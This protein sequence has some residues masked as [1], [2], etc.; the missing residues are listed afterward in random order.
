MEKIK[1]KD[2]EWYVLEINKKKAKLLLAD[3]LDERHIKKYVDDEWYRNGFEVR[4]NFNIKANANGWENSYI[5]N[6]VLENFKKDLGIDCK[7]TLLTQSEIFDLDEEIRCCNEDYWTKTII[8][9]DVYLSF[10]YVLNHGFS[11]YSNASRSLGIRPVLYTK[12]SNLNLTT[13]EIENYIFYIKI[14]R[15][16]SYFQELQKI[17]AIKEIWFRRRNKNGKNKI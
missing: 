12:T 4:H 9:N 1:F 8:N 16:K 15:I 5:K 2:L 10:A 13:E 3:V 7:V 14:Q 11:D 6:V 17:N